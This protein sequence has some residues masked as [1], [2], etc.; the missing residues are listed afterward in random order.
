MPNLQKGGHASVLLT[1]LRNFAI[2]A[3]QRG[4]HGPMA[5]PKYAPGQ[6]VIRYGIQA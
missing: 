2:L 4:G 3:T 5:P 1:F 6:T